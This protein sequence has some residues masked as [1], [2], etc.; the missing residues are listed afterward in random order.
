MAF[1]CVSET[2]DGLTG[3]QQTAGNMRRRKCRV[4]KKKFVTEEIEVKLKPGEKNPF[5]IACGGEEP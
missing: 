1:Y 3:V 4:C 5:W 2:C